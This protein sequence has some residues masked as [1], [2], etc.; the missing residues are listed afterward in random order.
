MPAFGTV[1]VPG[2]GFFDSRILE[3]AYTANLTDSVDI[4]TGDLTDVIHY[5]EGCRETEQ[6]KSFLM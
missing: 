1:Y 4:P 5:T 6:E 3:M 2:A